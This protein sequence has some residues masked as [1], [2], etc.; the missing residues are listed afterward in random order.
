MLRIDFVQFIIVAAI[1]ATAGL[2]T[3]RVVEVKALEL[4]CH[5][6]QTHFLL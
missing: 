4:S 3:E 6:V 5:E 2:I 1:K